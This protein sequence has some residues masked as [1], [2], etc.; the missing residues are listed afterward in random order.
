MIRLVNEREALKDIG[1]D[2]IVNEIP[3]GV[4]VLDLGCG[5]GDLLSLLKLEKKVEGYGVE[6][7]P[8]G[9]GKCIE[10]GVYAYQGDIDK[11]LF[12]YKTNSFDYV[13]INQTIQNTKR[14]D[15]VLEEVMRIGRRAIVSFPNFS[16]VRLRL[17]FFFRGTMP[18]TRALPYEWYNTPNI[19]MLTVIDF[20]R[21]CIKHGYT[22]EKEIHFTADKYG[23]S[24]KKILFPNFRAVYGFFVISS[25]SSAE[26]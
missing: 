6:I 26:K 23:R 17:N 4:K 11:D 25:E 14:T 12:H 21:F 10:K 8:E 7:S 13:I 24:A 3:E 5:D 9:V 19:R 18:V 15:L 22:I 16:H 1:Y 20:R 2:L